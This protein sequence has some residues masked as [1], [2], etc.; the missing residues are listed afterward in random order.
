MWLAAGCCWGGGGR[1]GC[2][3]GP[4]TWVLTGCWGIGGLYTTG[5][6][7]GLRNGWPERSKKNK[8][9]QRQ[10]ALLSEFGEN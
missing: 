1:G 8:H 3:A 4:G 7:S 9:S 10:T 5:V 6:P 2:C